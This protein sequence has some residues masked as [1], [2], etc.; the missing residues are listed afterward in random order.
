MNIPNLLT[1][2]RIFLIPF[3]VLVFYLPYQ[4]SHFASAA[5]FALAAGTDWL[6]GYLARLLGQ[7]T[8]FGSF[9]DPVADKLIVVVA[10]VLIVSEASNFAYISVPAAII[11][12]REIVV[13]ALRE[14]MAELGKRAS[15]RV[16]YVGKLKTAFQ[17]IALIMLLMFTANANNIVTILGITLL[18][19]S[20]LLTI[21]S[22][23][24]Y[25]RAAWPDFDLQKS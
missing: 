9:L 5:I 21:W 19:L 6:D 22:M 1:L 23:L 11:V 2:L 18:N 4:W 8:S 15:V 12:G 16:S 3:F 20:A 7:T 25:L 10:L 13:S 24:L 14:W 17:M